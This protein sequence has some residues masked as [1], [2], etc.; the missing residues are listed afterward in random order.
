MLFGIIGVIGVLASV[1]GVWAHRT[2]FDSETVADAVDQALL[3]PEVNEALAT[4]LTDQLVDA[5]PLEDLI[6]DRVPDELEPF[7]PVLVGGVRNVVHE[8]M[9]RVLE[10]G[11][12]R[13][14]LVAAGRARPRGGDARARGRWP[15]RWR[16]RVEGEDIKVNL[17]PLLSRGLERL[18]DRG[19]LTSVDLPELTA[20][21]DPEEQIAELEE[22]IDRDLPDDFGQLVVYSSEN[23]AKSKAAVARAQDAFA[24]F[25]RSIIA[26]V[27]L[28]V[29]SLGVSA[30][31]ATN[32]RRAAI[33]LLLSVVA[34]LVVGRVLVRT[35]VEEAPEPG[36]PSP[37]AAPRSRSW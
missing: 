19:I 3:N 28:T 7:T 32:R 31:L 16:S 29:V 12:A 5:V 18:Q 36:A 33:A 11:R 24:L 10:D 25:R 2:V 26:L 13:E 34:A 27:V 21:G 4:F 6:A 9:T 37:V 35:V 17:L 8:G 30:A 15:P 22:A 23:V 1:V 20:D 14:A